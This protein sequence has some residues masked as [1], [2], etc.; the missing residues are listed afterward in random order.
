[1]IKILLALILLTLPVHAYNLNN[2]HWAEKTCTIMLP[3]SLS[4]K[5][6]VNRVRYI[7]GQYQASTGVKMRVK[8]YDGAFAS[9]LDAIY[10]AED[11]N[12]IVV[13]YE[14]GEDLDI[15]NRVANTSFIASQGSTVVHAAVVRINDVRLQQVSE[16]DLNYLGNL[17]GH[18]VGHAFGLDHPGGGRLKNSIMHLGKFTG[19]KRF[20]LA[21]SDKKALRGIY[22]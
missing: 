21:R 16:G 4:D 12:S 10:F 8:V 14:P 19:G 3:T 6:L 15:G 11:T 13:L 5:K 9:T 2:K 22:R 20:G 7:A 17:I 1:M 18:E